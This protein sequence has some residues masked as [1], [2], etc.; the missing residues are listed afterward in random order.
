M[1][2]FCS[3]ILYCH[4]FYRAAEQ[5]GLA[6]LD[7][8]IRFFISCPNVAKIKCV[9]KMFLQHLK[10]GGD[11]PPKNRFYKRKRTS[12]S[13][14]R[15]N[16]RFQTIYP[17]CI[18][19]KHIIRESVSVDVFLYVFI[20][21]CVCLSVTLRTSKTVRVKKILKIR[22]PTKSTIAVMPIEFQWT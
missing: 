2:I 17:Y 16:P 3:K 15:V 13:K 6:S 19:S 9:A 14:D 5:T 21:L 22:T 20:C 12:D 8:N 18:Q 11:F 4:I 7:E 10:G 1:M